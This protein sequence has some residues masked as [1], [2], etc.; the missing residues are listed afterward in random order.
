MISSSQ[1]NLRQSNEK[2]RENEL[3]AAE[4]VYVNVQAG[5]AYRFICSSSPGPASSLCIKVVRGSLLTFCL[6]HYFFCN[7]LTCPHMHGAQ[8]Y[9]SIRGWLSKTLWAV[10]VFRS[11]GLKWCW[12]SWVRSD[13]LPLSSNDFKDLAHIKTMI[14]FCCF[15]SVCWFYLTVCVCLS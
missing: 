5:S 15:E 4:F 7:P 9:L 10:N 14:W 11:P 12:W 6:T 8:E 1:E 13:S 2:V 3:L